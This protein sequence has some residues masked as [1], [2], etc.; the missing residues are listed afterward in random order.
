MILAIYMNYGFET[1]MRTM[2]ETI[3]KC[4]LDK[5]IFQSIKPRQHLKRRTEYGPS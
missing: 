1:E 2:M 5:V 3:L 4:N